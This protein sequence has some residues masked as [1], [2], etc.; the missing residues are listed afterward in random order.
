MRGTLYLPA[1]DAPAPL[2][3]M[4][5]AASGGDAAFP[6]YDHLR[7]T[8]P[9]FGIAT[10]VYD[11]R[12]ANG[13][14]GDF[15]TATFEDLAEDGIE[16]ARQLR[17][18]PAIDANRIGAWGISQGGWVAP[19]AARLSDEISFAIAVS[20]PG[21]S[22]AE[23][24]SFTSAFHLRESGFDD[25]TVQRAL[26]LRAR[27]DAYF[28][29]PDPAERMRLQAEIDALRDQPWFPLAFLPNGGYLPTDVT[30]SKW[31]QEMDFDPTTN[32]SALDVPFLAVFGAKDRWVPVEASLAAIQ[33]AVREDLLSVYVSDGSGHL[34]SGA[35]EAS[36]YSGEGAVEQAYVEQIVRW[37]NA[38][39]H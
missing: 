14:P 6:F 2:L 24:M 17:S 19:V 16:A 34:M 8:L 11:R 30:T 37:V 27:V 9:E 39:H 28:R 21:V 26:G 32:L 23:Q 31:Y 7:T 35:E 36:D 22:P 15:E 5:H 18:H 20:G 13:Q 1:S 4:F 10:F 38:L 3:I 25:S 12:G 29:E 33:R